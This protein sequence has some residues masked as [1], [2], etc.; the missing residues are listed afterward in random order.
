[1]RKI[2]FLL[3]FTCLSAVSF[4]QGFFT[5]IDLSGKF[6]ETLNA[7]KYQEAH[8]FFDESVKGKVSPQA[9]E[10]IWKQMQAQLGPYEAIEG[11]Q[12]RSKDSIQ[13]VILDCKFK[14][15]SQSFQFIYNQQQK[16]LG[17]FLAPKN[18]VPAYKPAAYADTTAY[19]EDFVTIKTGKYELPGMITLPKTGENF[20]LV[21]LVHGSGPLDMDATVG[22][23][24]PF[25]DI[26]AGL[27]AKGV[28]TI[29]YV[30][31]T[32]L[33]GPDFSG[34]AF[35]LKEEVTEDVA[36]AIDFAKTLPE[37]NKNQI[38]V[39]G[40]SL[41][42]MLAPGIA[43]QHPD[44]KGIIL[45]AAPARN[46][47]DVATEQLH[48]LLAKRT[49]TAAATK[50]AFDNA[51]NDFK[52]AGQIKPNTLPA[53]S[54][55]AGLPVSYWLDINTV[56]QANVAKKL[57]TQILVIQGGND[58]QV[59]ETDFNLWR[60]ALKGKK[61]A[62]FKLY[63]ML[64]HAFAFVSEKGDGQQYLQPG[65]VDEIVVSDIAEW[66]STKK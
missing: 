61:N 16:L 10:T 54:V 63:P 66:I 52:K 9:L 2:Y 34:K 22:A 62:S 40:H 6:F 36:S 25:K 12:N 43:T 20:P 27:A 48:Y 41:G 26:A 29:R 31:R 38:Y 59:T 28:A 51:I 37:I 50:E 32:L 1:M 11:A 53:D 21:I 65:N 58:Y 18:N 8:D 49:D 3:F 13:S 57:K 45:A 56:G 42:G 17:F 46:F 30:K 19:K 39:L 23:N 33:Y 14:Y 4:A 55:I 47:S 24:K 60:N 44:L 5:Y 15:G 35:T 7:D 64:N